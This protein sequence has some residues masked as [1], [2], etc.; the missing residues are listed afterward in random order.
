MPVSQA[1]VKSVLSG[2]TLVLTSINNP[3]QERIL[4]LAFV[5]APRLRKEDDEVRISN[6][7]KRQDQ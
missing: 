5:R 1:K 6:E 3:E 2:D 7:N 4:S